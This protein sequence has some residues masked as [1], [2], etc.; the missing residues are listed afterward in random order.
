MDEEEGGAASL[1]L[2]LFLYLG[3]AES[4]GVS[5]SWIGLILTGRATPPES[6]RNGCADLLGIPADELFREIPPCPACG[7]SGWSA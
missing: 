1:R 2:I 5:R 7:G 6:F 3:F 4:L